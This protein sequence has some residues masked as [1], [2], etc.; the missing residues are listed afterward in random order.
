[1]FLFKTHS[2]FLQ[3]FKYHNTK[4]GEDI[5]M[6]FFF[7][8]PVPASIDDVSFDIQDI[9]DVARNHCVHTQLINYHF[10]DVA[11]S[12]GGGR[13]TVRGDTEIRFDNRIHTPF[14]GSDLYYLSPQY[15]AH[16][17]Y[18]DE[19]GVPTNVDWEDDD[20]FLRRSHWV[21]KF[22]NLN[23]SYE[24]A[25]GK[26]TSNFTGTILDDSTPEP[27]IYVYEQ[28][29]T[30]SAIKFKT[31][32]NSANA[33]AVWALDWWDETLNDGAGDWV[34]AVNETVYDTIYYTNNFYNTLSFPPVTST[35]FRLRWGVSGYGNFYNTLIN[36]V[37]PQ[38]TWGTDPKTVTWALIYPFINLYNVYHSRYHTRTFTNEQSGYAVYMCNVGEVGSGAPIEL[39]STTLDSYFGPVIQ[40]F[41]LEFKDS[42]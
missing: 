4:L 12:G 9:Y 8:G 29:V 15:I 41:N 27:Q 42:L 13:S 33:P 26:T 30:V 6:A 14:P 36:L 19:N 22:N 24:E 25:K 18:Q 28:E 10:N 16:T 31:W 3:S 32:S 34:E 7:D 23:R 11:G 37:G 35:R 5:G 1:M 21:Y 2:S 38:P 20:N 39:N 40:N 17:R